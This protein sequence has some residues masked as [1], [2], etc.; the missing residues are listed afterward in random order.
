MLS[1]D[2]CKMTGGEATEGAK[3]GL[4]PNIWLYA[5]TQ[6][7]SQ[8]HIYSLS[9]FKISSFIFSILSTVG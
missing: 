9:H 3:C 5:C 8:L 2:P 7:S 1:A 6:P 4:V